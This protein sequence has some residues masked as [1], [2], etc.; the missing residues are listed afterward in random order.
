MQYNAIENR[1]NYNLL[2]SRVV[3]AAA[4]RGGQQVGAPSQPPVH[5]NKDTRYLLLRLLS[6]TVK[7]LEQCSGRR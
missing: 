4:A 7:P 3:A 1:S 6:N 5:A 2:Q